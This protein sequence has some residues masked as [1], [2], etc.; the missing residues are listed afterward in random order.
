MLGQ[1]PFIIDGRQIFEESVSDGKTDQTV[2]AI[3]ASANQK[4]LC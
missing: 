2:H 4:V 3:T 1:L